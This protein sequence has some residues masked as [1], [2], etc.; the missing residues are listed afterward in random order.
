MD[1]TNKTYFFEL[2]TSP[3][4]VWADSGKFDLSPGVPA[5]VLKPDNIDLS[6]D[7][8]GKFSGARPPS[9]TVGTGI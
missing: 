1:L 5:K 8:S 3:N 7:V 9:E 6:G 4:V 2:T